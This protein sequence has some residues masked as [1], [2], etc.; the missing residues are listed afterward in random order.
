MTE[1]ELQ[2]FAKDLNIFAHL[3]DK[4]NLWHIV[5]D[6]Y[7]IYVPPAKLD[8][9]TQ[10]DLQ[11]FLAKKVAMGLRLGAIKQEIYLN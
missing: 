6:E 9:F 1:Q 5:V 10:D 8:I 3:D 2:D 11:S 7:T 4:L